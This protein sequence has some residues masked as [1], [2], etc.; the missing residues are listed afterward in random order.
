VI[1]TAF[2]ELVSRRTATSL[3]ALGLLTATVGFMVLAST[4]KTTQAVLTGDIKSAWTTPYDIL[5]RPPG[6]Q[7]PAETEQGLVRPNF[8]GSMSGGITLRQLDAIRAIAGVDV[9]APVAIAGYMTVPASKQ[10]VLAPYAADSRFVAFRVT[11]TRIGDA[12]MSTYPAQ[13]TYFLAAAQGELAIQP[14]QVGQ[15]VERLVAGDQSVNC[16]KLQIACQG[17]YGVCP[18]ANCPMEAGYMPVIATTALLQQAVVV[19][20]IDPEAEA[21]LA[22]LD[23]CVSTGRYLSNTDSWSLQSISR[24]GV[25]KQIPALISDHTFV[26]ESLTVR[27]DRSLN[28]TIAATGDPFGQIK[29]WT[30]VLSNS[31]TSDDL[32]RYYF[33]VADKPIVSFSD[34][35][36]PGDVTYS[37][38]ADQ[39]TALTTSPDFSVFET[40]LVPN[41]TG[42]QLAPPEAKDLW[43]RN[44]TSHRIDASYKPSDGPPAFLPVGRYNPSCLEGFNPLAGGRMETYAPASVTLPDGRQLAPNASVT[45]YVNMP[46]TILTSLSGISVLDDPTHYDGAPGNAF[47]SVI[48]VR[49]A[50]T[51]QPGSVSEARL[52]RVAAA[53]HDATDLQVDIV[54]GASPRQIHVQLPAG[55]FGRPAM[56][57][58][59]P[60]SVKGVG[61]RFLTAVSRQNLLMFSLVLLAA[62]IL[63]A[64][65][66]YIAVRRR[67]SEFAV[68]RAVGW[69]PWRIA[70]LIEL[71]LLMLGIAVGVAGLGTGAIAIDLM[72]LGQDWW[73][74]V[75][76]VPLAIVISLLAGVAPAVSTMQGTTISVV[77]EPEPIRIR[78]L[79]GSSL[80]LGLRQ[81][82]AWRWD[83]AMGIAALV[84]GS[85]MLAGVELIAAGFRGQLDTTVLGTYLSGEVRPFHFVVAGLTLAVG[86][87]AAAQV[88]TLTYLDRRVQLATLRALGWPRFE[89]VKLLMGQAVGIGLF[90]AMLSVAISVAAGLALAAPLLAVAGAAATALAMTIVGAGL[91]VIGPLS[92]AYAADPA[93]GLRGE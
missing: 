90:A 70:L 86:A 63:V 47:I 17:R 44:L 46:P 89:V 3:T 84:L 28:P 9:A 55:L 66:A 24:F 61:F 35:W 4:A 22:G 59:E 48:R 68:L 20:G 67:R 11:A 49:V 25:V 87:I 12:G 52:S 83:L 6:H 57:V 16:T 40:S 27:V 8:L 36:T 80:T 50:G 56:I 60:W 73:T 13:V 37:R 71:E 31:W 78:R 32:Y 26:D 65:T 75:G 92:H 58:T 29:S 34:T 76:V 10:I 14:Q 81:A 41:A 85:A 1:F 33:D 2:R 39:L 54:K 93:A 15:G 7:A 21:R 69:P 79:P 82:L 42:E 62:T 43:F 74:I 19:A 45:G 23:R 5:V 18:V 77:A 38:S 72:H 30:R 64:Q 53:I 91:A 51:E 88:I